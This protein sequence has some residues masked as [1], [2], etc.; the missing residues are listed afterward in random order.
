MAKIRIYDLS[1][2]INVSNKDIIAHFAASGQAVTA[3]SGLTD[4]QADEV[5]KAFSK[6]SKP[7]P[8]SAPKA[9]P[10]KKVEKNKQQKQPDRK[11][12]V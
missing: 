6:G 11:S 12:V 9:E 8:A 7:A 5:R 1:K 4:E 2:E 3:S 10:E